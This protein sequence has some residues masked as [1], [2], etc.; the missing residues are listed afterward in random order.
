MIRHNINP[1]PDWQTTAN[2]IGFTFFN[3]GIDGDGTLWNENVAYE[4]T[5]GEVD[6]LDDATEALHEMSLKVV[7]HIVSNDNLMMNLDIPDKFHDMIKN[8]WRNKEPSLYGRFD[9]SY[10]GKS[11]PK[12]LEYNAD[13]PTLVIETSLMQWTWLQQVM[14]NCD[15]FNSFHEKMLDRFKY[16]RTLVPVNETFYFIGYP[17]LE[18]EFR[19][20]EYLE[21]LAQQTNLKTRFI[22]IHD[23]GSDGTNFYDLYNNV[24]KFWFKLYPWEW[25]MR[26]EFSDTLLKCNNGILEPIWKSIL[27]NKGFLP[28]M[29]EL[30]PDSP[31]ILPAF[32]DE[33][34]I[35]GD[36]VVKP[37]LSREGANI[38]MISG[39]KSICQ[40]DGDY[41]NGRNV[42]QKTA[43]LFC[44]DG[45]YAVIGSWIIG[46]KSAGIVMRDSRSPIIRSNSSVVPHYFK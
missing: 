2:D 42:Y 18:E 11:P 5:S 17:G 27:S 35:S 12:M 34:K 1:R 25:M 8:S 4:F 7:D 24:I 23:V 6:E 15:Q 45:N 38:N 37:I 39:G 36:Y 19:T 32:F 28:I 13:T 22:S 20:L 40:T 43:N 31:Y 33:N 29:Y 41:G 3:N 10:D 16:I 14:P 30:F 44:Q 46:N 9:L 21:D 26:E